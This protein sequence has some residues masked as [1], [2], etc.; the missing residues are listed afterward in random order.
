MKLNNKNSE[1]LREN[2][3]E[4]ENNLVIYKNFE[5]KELDIKNGKKKFKFEKKGKNFLLIL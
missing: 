5:D 1:N 4:A 2:K 3:D